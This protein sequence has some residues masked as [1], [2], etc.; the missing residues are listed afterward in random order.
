MPTQGF[1]YH[2]D[3]FRCGDLPLSRLAKEIGTPCYR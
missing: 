3:A 2:D 1:S